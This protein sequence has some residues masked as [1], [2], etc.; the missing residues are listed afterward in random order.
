MENL[1]INV[2]LSVNDVNM[3]LALLGKTTT[4][5]PKMSSRTGIGSFAHTIS[6]RR[7]TSLPSSHRRS[8]KKIGIR[9][10]FLCRYYLFHGQF[11]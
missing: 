1:V 4:D 3:I 9:I 11:D 2:S 5:Q 8:G 7:Q 10:I 6:P